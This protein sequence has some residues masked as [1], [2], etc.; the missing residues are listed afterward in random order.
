M[1]RRN[2]IPLIL[3]AGLAVLTAGF[4]VLAVLKSPKAVDLTVQNGTAATF[5]A[6]SFA[7]D[8]TSS[9]SSG[10]GTGTLTQVR[11]ITYQ[12]PSHMVV[13]R[14]SPNRAL[15]GTLSATAIKSVLS[16]YSAVTG[17]TTPWVRVGTHY[18]RTESLVEFSA[19]VSPRVARQSAQGQVYETADVDGGY[20]VYVN[21][22]VIVPNQTTTGGQQAPGGVVGETFRV[23]KI[24]GSPAPAV[25]S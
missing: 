6:S 10:P 1:A 24:N 19:R 3:V 20:L 12:A 15:L 21:L 23:L 8:L 22:H 14:E 17:G 16:G 9:V 11:L 7:L 18:Q 25:A 2:L 13:Y 4:A 5:G